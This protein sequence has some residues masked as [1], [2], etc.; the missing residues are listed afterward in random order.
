[1]RHQISFAA[2]KWARTMN[3][4]AIVRVLATVVLVFLALETASF[5]SQQPGYDLLIVNG[6]IVDGSGNPWF[7]GSV[8]VKDGKIVEIGRLTSEGARRVIDARGM[9]VAP[10]FIDLHSHSDFTLL[11]D[12]NAQSKIR[13]GVTTEILGESDSAGPI[14]GLAVPGSDSSL[15]VLGITRDWTT[16]QEY[17][18]RLERQGIS[19]NIASFVGSGQVRMDVL[20]N[21]NRK[22]TPEELDKMKQLVDQ[23]MRE[24]AIGLSSGLIYA[25]NMY[26]TTEELVELAR[27]AA[28]YGVFTAVTFAEKGPTRLTLFRKPLRFRKRPACRLT[29]FTSRPTANRIGDG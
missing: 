17:F 29:F 27:I 23:A 4:A 2:E 14:L 22:P 12:G 1:M 26:A 11:V 5:F 10:G 8:A 20:G 18:M 19:V 3:R 6:Q 15:S 9:I 7:A 21:V 13:Q 28:H 24:G 25:P 16:L